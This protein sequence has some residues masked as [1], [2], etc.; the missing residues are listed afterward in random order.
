MKQ[1]IIIINGPINSGKSTVAKKLAGIFSD[2]I[3]IEGD[4]LGKRGG[5]LEQ[6]I[7]TVLESIIQRCAQATNRN[8]FIAFPL[9]EEDWQYLQRHLP[10]NLIC[11]TLSP[12]LSTALSNRGSRN[13]EEW[14]KKRIREMY[15]EGYQSRDFSSLIQDNG[16]ES[17]DKTAQHIAAHLHK[18]L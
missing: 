10:A 12:P 3:F 13:I 14:E 18:I 15:R 11:I 16:L 6:W 1:N 9:R 2:A 17:A 8:I 4:G 5:A 7:A